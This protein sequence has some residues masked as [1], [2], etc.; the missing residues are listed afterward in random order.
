M[1]ALSSE[2]FYIKEAYATAVILL[3]IVAGINILSANVAKR[4]GRRMNDKN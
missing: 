1:Y 3:V 4:I 2:G